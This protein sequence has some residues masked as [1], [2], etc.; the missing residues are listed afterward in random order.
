[1]PKKDVKIVFFAAQFLCE[2]N[3]KMILSGQMD[4][5]IIHHLTKF[6]TI[7]SQAKKVI[8]TSFKRKNRSKIGPIK[9]QRRSI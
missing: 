7:Y 8:A 5:A 4:L 9:A 6:Q 2:R 3:F 1:M